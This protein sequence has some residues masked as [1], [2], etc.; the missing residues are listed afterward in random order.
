MCMRQREV[1]LFRIAR[2]HNSPSGVKSRDGGCCRSPPQTVA[3][4]IRHNTSP[5]LTVTA[6]SSSPPLNPRGPPSFNSFR[7]FY[8]AQLYQD[9]GRFSLAVGSS[10]GRRKEEEA[11]SPQES[12][13]TSRPVPSRRGDTEFCSGGGNF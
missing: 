13:R 7:K 11:A 8:N 3:H 2:G 10:G 9:L 4:T 1:R 5:R 6:A 12:N